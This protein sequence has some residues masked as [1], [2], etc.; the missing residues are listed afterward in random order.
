[1]EIVVISVIHILECVFLCVKI[2]AYLLSKECEEITDN[3][4][5]SI[6]DNK[7]LS[8]KNNKTKKA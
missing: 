2:E 7:T 4:T 6:T 8:M 1:M 3:K 5:L